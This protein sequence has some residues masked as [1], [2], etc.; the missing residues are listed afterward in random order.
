[1]GGLT[2]LVVSLVVFGGLLF[3]VARAP[4]PLRD[5][6]LFFTV[7]VLVLLLADVAIATFVVAQILTKDLGSMLANLGDTLSQ[8]ATLVAIP[9]VLVAWLAEMA[10]LVSTIYRRD[11]REAVAGFASAVCVIGILASVLVSGLAL[12]IGVVAA[13]VGWLLALVGR[14]SRM[15]L[16]WTALLV[17]LGASGLLT[18]LSSFTAGNLAVILLPL[19]LSAIVAGGSQSGVISRGTAAGLAGVA[20]VVIIVA[21]T[22]NGGGGSGKIDPNVASGALALFI[23]AG[24]FAVV[25]WIVAIAEAARVRA[26]GWLVVNVLLVMIGSLLFGMFGPTAEDVRQTR[27]QK[28]QRRAAGLA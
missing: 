19:A 23:V 21:G 7:G 24:A 10:W 8:P 13:V 28:Q 3:G 6:V 9:I 17:V 12:Y 16:G 18:Y 26:W 25:S 15:E 14:A 20:L 5:I 2:V 4:Q 1:M 22:L 27:L 11:R